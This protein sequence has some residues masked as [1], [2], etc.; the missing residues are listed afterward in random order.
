[1]QSG[2]RKSS[3]L[4]KELPPT[5]STKKSK[6]LNW[7]TTLR[8]RQC[9]KGAPYQDQL[10]LE[11]VRK[12]S[13]AEPSTLGSV[14][15]QTPAHAHVKYVGRVLDFSVLRIFCTTSTFP[16][17]MFTTSFTCQVT[18]HRF[19][20]KLLPLFGLTVMFTQQV[21]KK[22]KGERKRFQTFARESYLIHITIIFNFS[23]ASSTFAIIEIPARVWHSWKISVPSIKIASTGRM[24]A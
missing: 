11:A 23:T 2:R 9:S 15:E 18:K 20:E 5:P 10:S 6:S 8:Y 13:L 12:S 3:N 19:C 7:D 16:V 1:M 14:Q 17:P 22:K 4:E 24:G 21:K